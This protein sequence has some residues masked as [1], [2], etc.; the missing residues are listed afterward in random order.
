MDFLTKRS[1]RRLAWLIVTVITAVLLV[2]I[3]PAWA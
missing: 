2:G 3:I 1:R